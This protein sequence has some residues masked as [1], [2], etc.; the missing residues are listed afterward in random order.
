VIYERSKICRQ[1][2]C[3]ASARHDAAS[4][5]AGLLLLFLSQ[6]FV[7]TR[8]TAEEENSF[9]TLLAPAFRRNCVRCHGKDGVVKGEVNLLALKSTSDLLQDSDLLGRVIEAIDLDEMPPPSEPTLNP[10]LRERLLR[11]LKKILHNAVSQTAELARAPIRRLNR[12]QYNNAVQ[13]LFGLKVLVFPL[14][15]RMMRE[16]GDYFQPASRKVPDQVKVGSRPLGKSQLIEP[17]LGGVVAFPQDLRAEHG[18]DTQGDHLSLSPL[19]MESFLALS[20][21]IVDSNDFN[22]KSCGIWDEFFATPSQHSNL[23]I[24]VKKRLRRFLS[25]A[26]RRPV[27]DELLTRYVA[28]VLRRMKGGDSFTAGMKAAASAALASPRFLYLYDEAPKGESRTGFD[29]YALATRLSFFLWGSI[30]DE[31]LLSVASEGH[32]SQRD[33]L[34]KQVDRML[35]HRHLKRFCDSF[36]AQWLQL[37]RII[38]AVPDPNKYADFYLYAAQY[39]ASMHMMLEPL[40]LFETI[41]IEDRSILELID[42]DFTFRSKRLQSWYE[43]TDAKRGGPGVIEFDRMAVTDRR[44]GGVITSAAVLTMTSGPTESKPITRG[45]WIASVIFNDPPKPPPAD[46]PPLKPTGKDDLSLTIRERFKSHRTRADCAGCHTKLDP[47]GF[48]LENF[49]AVGRWRDRYE[50][51]RQV[52][53]SGT[54]FG[55]YKFGDVVE[56]KD[57]ILAEKDRFT[58]AFASHLL[59][60]GL[61][62]RVQATDI[63][64]LDT[65]V[66]ET[67]RAD[68]SIQRLIHEITQSAPFV[69]KP[70]A[71]HRRIRL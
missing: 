6:M 9:D 63:P 64:S 25:R 49:D 57:A 59:A 52:D 58:R 30:P 39:R 10:R 17:S 54:L 2:R 24:V 12:F 60:Y 7:G 51:G 65:I 23:P 55:K 4:M 29:E 71:Q 31:E 34:R 13:D 37:D 36:P 42:S 21:S 19:L 15:E 46:V 32:L 38:S 50:N 1:T 27:E 62:R 5:A 26:F 40:L 56:F 66:I 28:H 69:G 11:E 20:R 33:T 47:L 14:P 3:S 43:R 68:Y 70:R 61:G 18:F 22:R 67:A 53:S 44:E 8:L 45:A 48:A 35:L 16:Y 41:L